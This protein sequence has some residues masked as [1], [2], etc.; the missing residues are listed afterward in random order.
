[1]YTAPPSASI[2]DHPAVQCCTVFRS[3]RALSRQPPGAHVKRIVHVV[4]A[5]HMFGQSV[6]NAFLPRTNQ[7]KGSERNRNPTSGR[8]LRSPPPTTIMESIR[9]GCPPSFGNLARFPT[10]PACLV[11]LFLKYIQSMMVLSCLG[12]NPPSKLSTTL[13]RPC[14]LLRRR[15]LVPRRCPR[16]GQHRNQKR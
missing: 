7:R 10:S 1:M 9:F 16:A 12:L 11:S 14:L 6:P 8:R 5:A 15:R 4:L 2:H 3:H 13:V